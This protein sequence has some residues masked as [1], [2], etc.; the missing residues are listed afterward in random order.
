MSGFQEIYRIIIPPKCIQKAYEL[1]RYA[2]EN[3]VEGVALFAGFEKNN[4]FYVSQTIIP[5]QTSYRLELGLLYAVDGDEL[6]RI[7]VWLYENNLSIIAQ[8]HSHPNE[9]YH[10]E[11]DDSYPIVATKGG[12]SIVVPRFAI[13]PIDIKNWAVY[14]LSSENCWVELS[15]PETK[16]V[17][18]IGDD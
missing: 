14:R 9:A 7:N 6:H 16:K 10:S 5:K 12:I 4:E 3:R 8:I 15:Y 1:L 11:T 13:D 2:G 18:Q 17:I